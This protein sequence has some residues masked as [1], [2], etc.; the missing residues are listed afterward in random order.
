MK[1]VLPFLRFTGMLKHWCD[2]YCT[3]EIKQLIINATAT[4]TVVKMEGNTQSTSSVTREDA[5]A[6]LLYHIA[7]HFIG[8]LKFIEDRSIQI[9]NKVRTKIQDINNGNI[10]Y[11]H[12]T[13]GDLELR[14][15]CRDFGFITPPDK[16]K[17]DKK[18]I[19]HRKKSGRGDDSSRS[20]IKHLSKRPRDTKLD[21]CS[22]CGKTG[23]KASDCCSGTKKKKINLVGMDEETKVMKKTLISIMIQT[24]ANQE[25]IVPALKPS[26]VVIV[27][28]I[29][30]YFLTIRKKLSLMSFNT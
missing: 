12:L 27:H 11:R 17:K 4:E 26:V 29:S 30:E 22:T 8:E 3:D 28:H 6:T 21:I 19:S 7:K 15:F 14:S 10:P 18:E 5:C 13:Y 1:W 24:K 20:K 9:Q 25:K 23:H 16:I 2:K